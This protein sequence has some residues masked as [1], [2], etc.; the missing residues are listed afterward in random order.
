MRKFTALNADNSIFSGSF[1]SLNKVQKK[2]IFMFL[3]ILA[4]PLW[5]CLRNSN[6][7]LKFIMNVFFFTSDSMVLE[8][9]HISY[10]KYFG[11][12]P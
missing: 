6:E 5:A 9:N 2:N 8:I 7:S 3:Y 10:I 12:W 1:V 4:K 11:G